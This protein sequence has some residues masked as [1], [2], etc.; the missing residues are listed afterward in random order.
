MVEEGL[1]ILELAILKDEVFEFKF[2][3]MLLILVE[4]KV[5]TIHFV[6]LFNQQAMFPKDLPKNPVFNA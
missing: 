6:L 4:L 3:R 5:L 1:E 2:S